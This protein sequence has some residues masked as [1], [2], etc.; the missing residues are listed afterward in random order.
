[1]RPQTAAI[2]VRRFP[3]WQYC[4]P[5]QILQSLAGECS[6]VDKAMPTTLGLLRQKTRSG[7]E[8]KSNG[9]KTSLAFLIFQDIGGEKQ[10]NTNLKLVLG[11]GSSLK[12][13]VPVLHSCL[14]GRDSGHRA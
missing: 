7:Q 13:L 5:T 8:T 3:A 14:L 4:I 10:K 1:M 12:S 9:G 6:G 11:S 2:E